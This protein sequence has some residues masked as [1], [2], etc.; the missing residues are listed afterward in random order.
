MPLLRNMAL[1]L[2][3]LL[4]MAAAG[5]ISTHFGTDMAIVGFVA[6]LCVVWWVFEPIPIPVTSLLPW[7]SCR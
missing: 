3:P 1:W 5:L 4:A 7:R 2:G 6:V